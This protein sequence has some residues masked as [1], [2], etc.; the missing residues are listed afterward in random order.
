LGTTTIVA[1]TRY[2]EITALSVFNGPMDALSFFALCR[3][4]SV[5]ALRQGIA[6]HK[7]AGA[8]EA[9]ERAGV[10]I[11]YLPSYGPDLNPIGQAFAKLKAALRVAIRTLPQPGIICA[12]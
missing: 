2:D 3:A 8:K 10:T 4:L 12:L 7:V 9:I 11:F 5:P 6:S 1:A